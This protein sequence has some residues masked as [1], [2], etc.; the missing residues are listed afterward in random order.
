MSTS[1]DQPVACPVRPGEPCQLCHPGAH[2]PEDCGL[3]YLVRNDPDLCAELQ[4]LWR[5]HRAP[6]PPHRR[7]GP[8]HTPAP[9]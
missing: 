8:Q 4:E 3:V 6:E 9:D 2:G 5:Q 1:S 7:P